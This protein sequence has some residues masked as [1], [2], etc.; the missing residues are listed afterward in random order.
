MD[1]RLE[2]ER[3]ELRGLA[4]QFGAKR[5]VIM[6]AENGHPAVY[7]WR[8]PPY[9]CPDCG[10]DVEAQPGCRAPLARH[11]PLPDET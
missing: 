3:E 9:I 7:G 8:F 5:V 11:G 4:R 1:D 6:P 10:P 2:F